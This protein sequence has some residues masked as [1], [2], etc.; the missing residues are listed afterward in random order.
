MVSKQ[1]LIAVDYTRLD[2]VATRQVS[3]KRYLYT[4]PRKEI[5]SALAKFGRDSI[6]W[7]FVQK[8]C[9]RN[10]IEGLQRWMIRVTYVSRSAVTCE[11]VLPVVDKIVVF[12]RFEN[13]GLDDIIRVHAN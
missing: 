3:I 11:T 12:Q 5:G 2:F 7:K 4:W 13:F 1:V 10:H 6:R 9:M 8:S